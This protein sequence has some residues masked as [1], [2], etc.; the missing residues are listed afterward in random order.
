MLRLFAVAG[1]ALGA[2]Q[3]FAQPAAR[4]QFEVASIKRNKSSDLRVMVRAAPSGRFTLI[5]V[6][7]QSA[8]T[9]AYFIKKDFQVAGP[10]G[11]LRRNDTISR[12]GPKGI[13]RSARCASCSR[14][15]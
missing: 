1:L 3:A 10:P 8:V 4:P 13:R 14:H 9:L 15:C 6:P 5:N 12:A 11:C 2:C 7:M